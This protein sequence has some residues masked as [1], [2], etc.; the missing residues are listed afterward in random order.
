EEAGVPASAIVEIGEGSD[1]LQSLEAAAAVL[2]PQGRHSVL[3]VTDPE[4]V[5][6]SALMARDLGFDVDAA[7]V[8]RPQDT[9]DSSTR[10]VAREVAGTL[11]HLVVG[12]SSG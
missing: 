12:G 6:R 4:H 11:F 3:L 8:V 2:Q 5:H 9:A 10:Y 1:T 7:G